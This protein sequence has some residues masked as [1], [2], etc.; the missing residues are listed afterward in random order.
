MI[1]VG[2]YRDKISALDAL[3][4]KSYERIF[5][6]F[7][8]SLNDKDF[9]TYN[10]LKKIEFPEIDSDFIQFYNVDSRMALTTISYKIYG[11][12]QSWW[13]IYLLNKDKFQGA[14]FYVNGGVQLSYIDP[15]VTSLIYSDITNS[16]IFGGR[17][18]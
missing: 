7:T 5:K 1:D 2:Q 15:G 3:S 9:Y 17:H 16:T 10:T 13:I 8:Q 18:Y 4:I 12:I 14:P 6:V 11:D